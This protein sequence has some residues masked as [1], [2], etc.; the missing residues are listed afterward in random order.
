[1]RFLR[2][3]VTL[4][5][6]LSLM[7]I[8]AAVAVS[9]AVL[10][11][12]RQ[13]SLT[14]ENFSE[15]QAMYNKLGMVDKEVRGNFYGD[16]D[17]EKLLDSLAEAYVASLD[18][19]FSDY[20]TADEYEKQSLYS[21]GKSVGIGVTVEATQ[22]GLIRVVSVDKG[23]PASAAGVLEGDI[24]IAVAGK[25]VAEAGYEKSVES[26]LGKAGTV[27]A[28][29]VRRGG[30]TKDFSIKREEFESLSVES[31]RV[32]TVG[33]VKIEG[34]HNN[35]DEQFEKAVDQLVEDGAKGLIFDVR[36]NGGGTLD[37]VAHMIDLLVPKGDIVSVTS[38]NGRTEVMYKS[39]E[40]EIDLPMVVLV[41]GDTASAS[42][43]FAAALRD[44]KKATVIG[45]QTYG[46]GVMQRTYELDD[47]SAVR[48][49]VGLFNPPSGKNFNNKGVKPDVEVKLTE[50]QMA[51]FDQLTDETD[52]QIQAALAALLD[53]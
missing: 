2:K 27:C 50:E 45:T 4:G 3:K 49:T 35:T 42:E 8:S 38:K 52:P 41:D 7:L 11:T 9:A 17:N 28:F 6:A 26:M 31:R 37:S 25:S 40:K 19:R 10:V 21:D 46:K 5:V 15:R 48:V 29:T 39:D 20:M 47:G 23:A 1:M 22:D 43:L 16:I 14:V 51:N 33:Y 44:Y 12:W 53:V 36:G 13:F 30:E 24:V 34:F 18:D 32:G